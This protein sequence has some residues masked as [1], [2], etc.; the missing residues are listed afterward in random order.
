MTNDYRIEGNIAYIK[1]TSRQ[2]PPKEVAIEL[3]SLPLAQ[4]IT[5]DWYL[6]KH[7]RTGKYYARGNDK[8]SG[9]LKQ[10][11]LHRVIMQPARGQNTQHV[12][13]N[14][15]NCVRETMVNAA[16]GVDVTAAVCE[17]KAD[18]V[19]GVAKVEPSVTPSVPAGELAPLKGVSLHKVKGRWEV[20]PFYDG[21]RHRLG[22]WDK[23]DLAGANAAVTEFR[24]LGP[25]EYFKRY[26]KESKGVS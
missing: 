4:A 20:S 5:G 22:Y 6:Y 17:A 15:L 21:K 12:D 10:P 8:S 16:I 11:L 25:I 23:E 13:G 14:T 19:V 2:Q 26:P 3:A 18:D 9:K 7:Q 24:E 1:L